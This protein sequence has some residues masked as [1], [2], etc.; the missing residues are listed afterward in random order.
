MRAIDLVEE[1]APRYHS[2]YFQHIFSGGYSA[3]YYSYIWAE[4]LD[5]DGYEAFKENGIFDAATA[6]SFRENILER[7]GSAEPLELYIKFRGREPDV[8]PLLKSRGLN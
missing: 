2:T 8:A 6:Q 5:T 4:V 3:G 1:V 7:G